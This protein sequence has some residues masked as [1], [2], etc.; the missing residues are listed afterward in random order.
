MHP[1]GHERSRWRRWLS[2]TPCSFKGWN[3]KENTSITLPQAIFK[4]VNAEKLRG[5]PKSWKGVERERWQVGTGWRKYRIVLS[6]QPWKEPLVIEKKK[7]S[8][9]HKIPVE[10]WGLKN[11][12]VFLLFVSPFL[13]LLFT[14]RVA[15]HSAIEQRCTVA[16][17]LAR[18]LS[19][20]ILEEIG[21][22]TAQIGYCA[23]VWRILLS[24]VCCSFA[25]K[26]DINKNKT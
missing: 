13:P 25:G 9:K 21:G 7:K 6:W 15:S 12:P 23:T 5:R 11:K 14:A 24:V 4:R 18:P 2:E 1:L 17:G 26:K 20:R 16:S 19:A 22:D 3:H 10:R 8:Q